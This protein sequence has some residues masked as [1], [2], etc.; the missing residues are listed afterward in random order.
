[1][2]FIFRLQFTTQEVRE[3][4]VKEMESLYNSEMN[5]YWNV[6]LSAKAIGTSVVHAH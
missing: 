3:K 4:T 5:R 6:Y 1:M 2:P